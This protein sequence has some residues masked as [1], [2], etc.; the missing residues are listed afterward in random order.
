[1]MPNFVETPDWSSLPRPTDD[2]AAS[3]LLGQRMASVALPATDGRAVNPAAL[4][5]RVVIYAYPR[6]G[7]PE[8]PNPEGWDAIPGARGC[9]PQSCAFK[10]HYHELRALGVSAVFGLSTQD[11]DYQREA[12]TRLHLPFP[13]LSDDQLRLTRAMKLPTF[14]VGTMAVL[15]RFT[16]IVQDGQVQRVFYP[17]FPPDQNAAEVVAWLADP[18]REREAPEPT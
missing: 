10:D 3:H 18:G 7:L 17:V 9:T 13:L 8:V 16:L 4:P 15:K 1:M 12:A 5:G 6:T 14:A 11:S 2:G